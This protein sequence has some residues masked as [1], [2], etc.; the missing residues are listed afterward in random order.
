MIF[1]TSNKL[2]TKKRIYVARGL[3]VFIILAFSVF[4]LMD[5]REVYKSSKSIR[6]VSSSST[7]E[8]LVVVEAKTNNVPLLIEQKMEEKKTSNKNLFID[9]GANCGNSYWRIKN[10]SKNQVLD[11]DDWETYLWECNPQMNKF[12][13][14]ELAESN[15]SIHL[16]EKAAT[17]KDG[18][19][20][21]YLTAGQEEI[22]HKSQFSEHGVCNPNSPYS[23]SGASTIFGGAKRAGKNITVESV[24]FVKWFDDLVQNRIAED[25]GNNDEFKLALKIDA[26]GAEKE[27]LERMTHKD[28][29]DSICKVNML[30]MEYHYTIFHEG[31]DEYNAHLKFKN[32]F[33]DSFETK[34]GR[35]LQIGDWH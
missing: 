31:T 24:N 9:I 26:E 18:F 1:T 32:E 33:P 21:F 19:L 28:A 20:T 13:L 34:C 8:D 16:I 15:P 22:T 17:T 29:S 25:D 12:F 10:D 7:T 27:I 3:F 35:R 6:Q 23:P 5:S 30:W 11:S 14:R 4:S 2:E